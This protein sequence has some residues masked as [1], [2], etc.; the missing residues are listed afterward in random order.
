MQGANIPTAKF[1]KVNSLKE[2]KKI[3]KYLALV[4]M[5]QDWN[6]ANLGQRNLCKTQIFQLQNFGQ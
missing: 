1:W 5:E 6:I 4:K 3:I 2:A